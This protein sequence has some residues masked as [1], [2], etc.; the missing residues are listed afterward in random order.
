M[1]TTTTCKT[2]KTISLIGEDI[3]RLLVQA[4]EIDSAA[5]A[6]VEFK[7]PS[8]GDYSGMALD[9]DD[10]SPVLVRVETEET[11]DE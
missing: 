1:K 7:V 9:V 3:R 5:T 10:N 4:G 2:I 11:R 8:G 6:V